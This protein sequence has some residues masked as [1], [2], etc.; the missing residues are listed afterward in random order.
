MSAL[1]RHPLSALP[2]PPAGPEVPPD[3]LLL[4]VEQTARV[5]QISRSGLYSILRAD[6]GL[7]A[8]KLGGLTRIARADLEAYVDRLRA[9]ATD[10]PAVGEPRETGAADGDSGH[11]GR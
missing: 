8:V 10:A 9:A 7:R 1:R 3:L 2:D 6:G 11:H 5:L 4:T